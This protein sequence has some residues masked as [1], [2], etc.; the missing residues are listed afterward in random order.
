MRSCDSKEQQ[1]RWPGEVPL[2]VTLSWV[3]KHLEIW[4]KNIPDIAWH[5]E[6]CVWG[7]DMEGQRGGECRNVSG[8]DRK[9]GGL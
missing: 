4:V 6:V 2:E 5:L 8:T 3:W 9:P 1:R 7:D